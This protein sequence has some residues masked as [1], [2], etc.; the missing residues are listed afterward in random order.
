MIFFLCVINMNNIFINDIAV[1]YRPA[2]AINM[3]NGKSKNPI[4]ADSPDTLNI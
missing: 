4:S 2:D 3:N 1:I